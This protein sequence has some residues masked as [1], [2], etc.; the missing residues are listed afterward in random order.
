[1]TRTTSA[2]T[3][4]RPS[5]R[6]RPWLIAGVAASLLWGGTATY[7]ALFRDDAFARI[8][9]GQ[10]AM[11]DAYEARIVGL[12][13]RIEGVRGEQAEAGAALAAR[14][15]T[16]LDRQ[17]ELERRQAALSG[18]VD[19]ATTGSISP[20]RS[21]ATPFGAP[22]GGLGLRT[23]GPAAAPPEGGRR[24]AL[25]AEE[26]LIRLEARLTGLQ[27]AQGTHLGRLAA[28]AQTG[29]ARLRAV[30]LRTGLDP[31]RLLPMAQGSRMGGPL[32][33]LDAR[34]LEAHG[35]ESQGFDGGLTLVGRLLG[36][37]ERM[38]RLVG[39]L[40][41]RRPLSGPPVL[42]SPFG[43]RLDPFTRGL[44]LHTGLDFKAEMGEPARA[45]A[46][47][48]VT[49]ADYAGGYG[50][51]VE[52]THGHGLATRFGHLARIA[53]R[54]GQ[55]IA[56]GDVIGYVGSTGRSTGAHLHYETRIDGEPVDPQRFLEAG[57]SL[58]GVRA[59]G[60]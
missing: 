57:R 28:G 32:V 26:G 30:I 37:G 54:P 59:F 15:Q 50:N 8:L 2:Q 51:M 24:S 17:A 14:V 52:I 16:A 58:D 7:L 39:D 47:G 42:S 29:L 55:R 31:S 18:L 45:T 49:E 46:P 35:V 4:V 1:M 21:P 44:A 40:P 36:D 38:R 33:P 10:R 19:A 23:D 20:A 48:V 43:P 34:G 3:P 53:V 22:L 13:E 5:R 6:L 12:Q 60:G 41:L 27:E 11:R 9:D 56:A 25:D